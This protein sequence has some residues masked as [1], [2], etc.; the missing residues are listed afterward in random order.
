MKKFILLLIVLSVLVFS[1]SAGDTHD[2]SLSFGQYSGPSFAK[3]SLNLRYGV[4]IG[5]TKRSE[6]MVW[7]ASELTPNIFNHNKI[8]AGL[9]FALLGNR[10]TGSKVQGP[11]CNML[12]TA[13]LIAGR[14]NDENEFRVTSCYLSV[15]PFTLGTP[16][17]GRRERMF[18]VGAEYNWYKNKFSL[19]ISVINFDYYIHGSWKDYYK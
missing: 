14:E 11:S 7:G 3:E 10:S 18:E 1:L 9:S 17:M 15:T 13:G 16:I 2:V 4:N 8:G 5:L 12:I 19:F 6:V